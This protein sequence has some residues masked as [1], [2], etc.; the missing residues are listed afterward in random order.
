MRTHLWAS[1]AFAA[2]LS[3][4]TER[5]GLFSTVHVPMV[6]PVFAAKAEATKVAEKIDGRNVVVLRQASETGQLYGSVS[7]RIAWTFAAG[8]RPSSSARFAAPMLLSGSS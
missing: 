3:G 1:L 7:V 6:H 5:I 4:V 2:A 8:A